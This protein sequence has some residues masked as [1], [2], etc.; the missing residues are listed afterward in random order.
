MNVYKEMYAANIFVFMQLANFADTTNGE[1]RLLVVVWNEGNQFRL[2]TS[3]TKAP[4][5]TLIKTYMPNVNANLTKTV[6]M[7]DGSRMNISVSQTGAKISIQVE[8]EGH[9][10]TIRMT[11]RRAIVRV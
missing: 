4:T 5:A 2:D 10:L 8:L 3:M 7:P 6:Q 9:D 11:H 1:T